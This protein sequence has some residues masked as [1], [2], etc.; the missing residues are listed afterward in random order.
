[1]LA[2][3]RAQ[4]KAA[5]ARQ[6]GA[7][8]RRIIEGNHQLREAITND[9][10]RLGYSRE[11]ALAEAHDFLK[12]NSLARHGLT[13]STVKSAA[14]FVEFMGNEKAKESALKDAVNVN[15]LMRH[16]E[17]ELS[18]AKNLSMLAL[19]T[20]SLAGVLDGN[21]NWPE[22]V[23][24]HTLQQARTLSEN[25]AKIA[26]DMLARGQLTDADKDLLH[27]VFRNCAKEL[28]T[29]P[30]PDAGKSTVQL[31]AALSHETA[32]SMLSPEQRTDQKYITGF[33]DTMSDPEQELA[34]YLQNWKEADQGWEMPKT[35]YKKSAS[36]DF[37]R[38]DEFSRRAFGKSVAAEYDHCLR[39]VQTLLTKFCTAEEE[40][41][42]ACLDSLREAAGK[43][44][45]AH[46]SLDANLTRLDR[47]AGRAVTEEHGQQRNKLFGQGNWLVLVSAAATRGKDR[48]LNGRPDNDALRMAAEQENKR[49]LN[50]LDENGLPRLHAMDP[51][52]LKEIVSTLSE[53]DIDDIYAEPDPADI[54]TGSNNGEELELDDDDDDQAI[55]NEMALDKIKF[56][57]TPRGPDA[58]PSAPLTRV[59]TEKD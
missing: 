45:A 33:D 6:I 37:D 9:L 20:N 2:E 29:L 35:L 34:S 14:M 18:L 40:H 22:N 46:R 7:G 15:G 28:A 55:V 44:T 57:R 59:K 13:A 31:L 8:W 21:S 52:A 53:D 17:M 11:E 5:S 43:A 54:E 32:M 39:E 41:K 16:V 23:P 24:E 3:V 30:A 10:V 51:N 26:N 36:F 47:A 27:D 58:S 19:Y 50:M 56:D 38:V 25:A 1:L 12:S 49:E 42:G 4:P 48:M